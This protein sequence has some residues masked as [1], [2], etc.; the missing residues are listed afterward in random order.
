[1]ALWEFGT[2]R[3]ATGRALLL[4]AALFDGPRWVRSPSAVL[5]PSLTLPGAPFSWNFGICGVGLFSMDPFLVTPA[6]YFQRVGPVDALTPR[7]WPAVPEA[8]QALR[9]VFGNDL[10]WIGN[11][12]VVFVSPTSLH[13]EPGGPV[14]VS[15]E[16][17]ELGAPVTW[18][19]N[20][21]HRGYLT[22]GHVGRLLKNAADD[23]KGNALGDV[24]FVRTASK[25]QPLDCASS[26]LD[27]AVIELKP[28]V[29]HGNRLK[30][31]S[32]V[33]PAPNASVDVYT[34]KGMRTVQIWGATKWWYIS[35]S[36]VTLTEIYLSHTGVTS[37][38][39][40]GG[41]VLLSGGSGEIIG[42]IVSGG[43]ATSC[44]QDI[45]HQLVEIR[46]D[47]TF[48]HIQI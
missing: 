24:V 19:V 22:A 42:H 45:D 25:G 15:A 6:L 29:H 34:R 33:V 32:T 1:M 7:P 40:S 11:T 48:Q 10:D 13:A 43:S 47:P 21:A 23:G 41:P 44:F 28:N 27:V 2:D 38:G 36:R 9:E 26:S 20:R 8:V 12:Q 31:A 17:G 16:N 3:D 14:H 37:S 18:G 30:I 5:E 4:A 35:S 39:D 46:K